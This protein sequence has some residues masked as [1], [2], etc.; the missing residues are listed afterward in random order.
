MTVINLKSKQFDIVVPK[1]VRKRYPN[2]QKQCRKFLDIIKNEEHAEAIVDGEIQGTKS[3]AAQF[4]TANTS[5]QCIGNAHFFYVVIGQEEELRTVKTRLHG[6]GLPKDKLIEV[7]SSCKIKA[8]KH[9][10]NINLS[11]A[12]KFE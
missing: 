12:L 11:T 1:H 8:E 3:A 6:M 9:L 2:M 7:S 5:Q 10:E 4:V